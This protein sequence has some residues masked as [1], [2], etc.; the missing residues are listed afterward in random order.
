MFER[1]SVLQ[2]AQFISDRAKSVSIRGE[3]I[4]ECAL[5]L[6]DEMSKKKYSFSTWKSH[7]LHPK[8]EDESTVEWIFM[9]DLLN[10]SFW[11]EANTE[12]Y[13]VHYKNGQYSGYWSLCAAINLAIDRCGDRITRPAFWHRA[14]DEEL[15][16]IFQNKNTVGQLPMLQ[17]RIQLL[18]ET[19]FILESKFEGSFLKMLQRA[20]N[21]AVKLINLLFSNLHS[22]WD[23]SSFHDRTVF[24]LKRAQILVADLWACFRGN[25][26][27]Y[28]E[29]IDVITMFADYRVPQQL[30][31]MDLL[32]L[33]PHLH[34]RLSEGHTLCV[35]DEDVLEL[36]ACSIW[37]VELL[38]RTI[39]KL[40]PDLDINAILIDFYLWD[41]AKENANQIQHIPIHR[42]RSVFY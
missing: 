20:E 17:E 39:K 29:D 27:G 26:F 41:I 21:N 30:Q 22:F 16:E 31:A 40:R 15:L 9:V 34:Q 19:G 37:V 8:T 7:P 28:F 4:D 35:H 14:T 23:V 24:L 6:I 11:P 2:S 3:K 25:S 12:P 42:T 5:K 1:D 10:F 38:R 36:R 33:R 32:W 13:R 18:R